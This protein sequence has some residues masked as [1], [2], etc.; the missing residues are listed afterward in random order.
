MARGCSRTACADLRG[1]RQKRVGGAAARARLSLLRTLFC[2][3]PRKSAHA[4]REHP[5]AI[6]AFC[7]SLAQA[8]DGPLDRADDQTTAGHRGR[9]D[10]L[11]IQLDLLNQRALVAV[12]HIEVFVLRANI[13]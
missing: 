3:D 4:V 9:T 6:L 7:F 12:Q 1:S 2:S 10:D 5:R 11:A 13:D 8:V